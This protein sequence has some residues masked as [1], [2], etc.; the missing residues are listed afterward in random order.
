MHCRQQMACDIKLYTP[1][2][3]GK[4]DFALLSSGSSGSLQGPGLS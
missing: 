3:V 4:R 1:F 2:L